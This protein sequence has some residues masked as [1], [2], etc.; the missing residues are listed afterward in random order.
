MCLV[1][2]D[3]Q[4]SVGV[5]GGRQGARRLSPPHTL[6]APP[7]VWVSASLNHDEPRSAVVSSVSAR[8]HP[9]LGFCIGLKTGYVVFRPYYT[10]RPG[11]GMVMRFLNVKNDPRNKTYSPSRK[12]PESNVTLK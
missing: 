6:P 7:S 8:C 1:S 2:V 10:D 3:H 5:S 11:R 4:V 9:S 12:S